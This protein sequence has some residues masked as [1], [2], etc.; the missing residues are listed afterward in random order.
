MT[1]STR[2]SYARLQMRTLSSLRAACSTVK[3]HTM[4]VER[5]IDAV[6]GNMYVSDSTELKS[7]F[8]C[9]L[10][11]STIIVAKKIHTTGMILYSWQN[12]GETSVTRVF[13]G[14]MIPNDQG[15]PQCAASISKTLTCPQN[16]GPHGFNIQCASQHFITVIMRSR[17]P[18]LMTT[19]QRAPPFHSIHLKYLT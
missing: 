14:F 18:S 9:H 4:Y 8:R 15:A 2:R 12:E 19:D 3:Y 10:I 5:N 7:Q 11:S 13:H 6:M 1:F 16:T 17:K